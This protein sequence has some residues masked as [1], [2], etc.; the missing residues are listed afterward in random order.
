MIRIGRCYSADVRIYKY[1]VTYSKGAGIDQRDRFDPVRCFL[2]NFRHRHSS[3]YQQEAV[4]QISIL[5]FFIIDIEG[6]TPI[7]TIFKSFDKIFAVKYL[8]PS[9]IFLSQNNFVN[10]LMYS[11]VASLKMIYKCCCGQRQKAF[12]ILLGECADSP[13]PNVNPDSFRLHRADCPCSSSNSIQIL[14]IRLVIVESLFTV[15][16]FKWRKFLYI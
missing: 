1:V 5:S 8:F 16:N 9:E 11:F 13:W 4:Y 6:D 14:R 10:L 15:I 2:K 12:F 3:Q 7:I